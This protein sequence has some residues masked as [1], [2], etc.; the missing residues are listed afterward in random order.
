M[1]RGYNSN[2]AGSRP[3][4][5]ETVQYQLAEKLTLIR[6]RMVEVEKAL[7]AAQQALRLGHPQRAARFITV[8]Q[9]TLSTLEQK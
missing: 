8:A 6:E 1:P 9:T 5:P 4:T 7:D 2:S 3:R